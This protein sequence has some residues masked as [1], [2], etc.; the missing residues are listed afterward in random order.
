MARIRYTQPNQSGILRSVKTYCHPT[1]GARY[2]VLL[3]MKGHKWSIVDDASERVAASGI[4]V[5]PHKI[6]IDA[7]D[8]LAALG[9]LLPVETRR[10]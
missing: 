5:H 6:R 10:R 4:R 2:K 8:A 3:D 7:R 9:V 1:N